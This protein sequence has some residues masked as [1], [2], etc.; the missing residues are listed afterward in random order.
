MSFDDNFDAYFPDDFDEQTFAAL[1]QVEQSYFGSAPPKND[2]EPPPKRQRT[3]TGW[4]HVATST[5]V[6]P[7]SAAPATT[8]SF[9]TDEL[10]EISV[11]NDA[12]A[13][14]QE[15]IASA[16]RQETQNK[17][18]RIQ[19]KPPPSSR[20]ASSS[21]VTSTRNSASTTSTLSNRTSSTASR[22]GS[23]HSSQRNQ[24]ARSSASRANRIS[25]IASALGTASSI[26]PPVPSRNVV[27]PTFIHSQNESTPA[28][29]PA[30]DE[31]PVNTQLNRIMAELE[32]LRKQNLK[33]QN[34]L[35]AAQD[36][37]FAKEGEVTLL[38]KGIERTAQEHARQI[39]DLNAAK[40][41][42]INQK[43]KL[44]KDLRAE[45]ERVKTHVLQQHEMETNQKKVPSSARQKN[46]FIS[47]S[48]LPLSQTPISR[49][50]NDFAGAGPSTQ[51]QIT[52]RKGTT[53]ARPQRSPDVS[54]KNA[55]LPGFENAFAASTPK[56]SS[57]AS[58]KP[59]QSQKESEFAVPLL[60]KRLF[61]EDISRQKSSSAPDASVSGPPSTPA[62]EANEDFPMADV[63]DPG[64]GEDAV[65]L[66]QTPRTYPEEDSI[67]MFGFFSKKAELARVLL[68]HAFPSSGVPTLQI[69]AE[70]ASKVPSTSRDVFS[71]SIP[72]ILSVISD[73]MIDDDY[74]LVVECLSQELTRL[75]VIMNHENLLKELIPLFN[76]LTT[77]L[78]TFPLFSTSLLSH[79]HSELDPRPDILVLFCDVVKQ[80]LGVDQELDHNFVNQTLSVL[81]ALCW[82][83]PGDSQLLEIVTTDVEVFKLLLDPSQPSW[84]LVRST[85][86]LVLLYAF[87]KLRRVT[88]SFQEVNGE[89]KV[90]LPPH[91]DNLC[92]YF[93]D[94]NA[95]DADVSLKFPYNVQLF[96]PSPVAVGG[97]KD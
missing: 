84:I 29:A 49:V 40:E 30:S 69:L 2:S 75:S 56:R 63:F 36:A 47:Q 68:T 52:P 3:E 18:S 19:S 50:N 1:D 9:D 11:S 64:P 61:V 92:V 88:F 76:L 78:Y 16:S 95:Q 39:A 71:S 37:R 25:I 10:P 65:V 33:F 72:R 6:Q 27:A 53:S 54:R 89:E 51:V 82:T 17:E 66:K 22:S 57:K 31:T 58:S 7:R 77:L 93:T 62:L 94:N 80:R 86:L 87:P 44:E 55:M 79:V 48:H 96:S 26:T 74:E 70:A 90:Q 91:L 46:R 15:D 97:R 59:S 21:R 38:R 24:S 13:F 4:S 67:E 85:R 20:L 41:D 83:T 34:E 45:V 5:T 73:T 43:N 42:L 81:E 28:V 35:K 8:T 14:N 12:Y 32:E 23:T 60:P